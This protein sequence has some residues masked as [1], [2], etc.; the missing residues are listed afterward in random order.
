MVLMSAVSL[1]NAPMQLDWIRLGVG[2]FAPAALIAGKMP[3]LPGL[4]AL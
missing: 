1:K 2:Q 4:T 3:A